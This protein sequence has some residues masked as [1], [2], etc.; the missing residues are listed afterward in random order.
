MLKC[1]DSKEDL[2][3]KKFLLSRGF[4]QDCPD[5]Q[6]S[7]EKILEMY[8][9]I[10]PA[11]NAKVKLGAKDKRRIIHAVAQVFVEQIFR[12]FDKDGNGS[13]DFK[14]VDASNLKKVVLAGIYARHRHDS[15]WLA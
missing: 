3:L 10:L 5:G 8:T 15:I 6:L 12:I 13:I 1:L 9:M 7:K 14:V 2:F 11:G 4:K